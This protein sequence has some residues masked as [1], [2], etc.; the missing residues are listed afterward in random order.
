[1]R[2]TITTRH[3]DIPD[4]LKER[5]AAIVER[6]GQFAHRPQEC[7][8]VFD[9]IHQ[10]PTAEVRLH[11]A[12][13]QVYVASAEGTDHRTALDQAEQKLRRQLD[14]PDPQRKKRSRV[15]PA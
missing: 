10:S 11:S 5:A 15:T 12:S 3:G 13:G 8:V 4:S 2:T 14:K 7:T 6:L 1:M 9:T